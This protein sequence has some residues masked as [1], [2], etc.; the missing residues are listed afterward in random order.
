MDEN[1]SVKLMIVPLVLF[2]I[3]RI[4]KFFVLKASDVVFELIPN[5]LTFRVVQ[6]QGMVLSLLSD[7]P[8]ITY[9]ISTGVVFLLAIILMVRGESMAVL[10][11]IGLWSMLAGGFSN[12]TDRLI[13]NNVIDFLQLNFLDWFIFNLADVFICVGAIL[14]IIGLL[15]PHIE[16]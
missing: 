7:N 3:D 1:Q 5:F 6:N 10:P 11:Y 16:Y 12:L 14:V 4:S 15:I 2:I 13:H 8:S 9:L